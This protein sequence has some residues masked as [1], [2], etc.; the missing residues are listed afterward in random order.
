MRKRQ[1]GRGGLVVATLALVAWGPLALAADGRVPEREGAQPR[2]REAPPETGA[3]RRGMG[4]AG[5]GAAR[6]LAQ[7]VN[8]EVEEKANGVTILV[9]SQKPD[10]AQRIKQALPQ[11][12]NAMR[13][14]GMGMEQRPGPGMPEGRPA[15]KP[16]LARKDVDIHGEPLDDGVAISVTSDN[17]KVAEQIKRVMPQRAQMLRGLLQ[18]AQAGGGDPLVR[19]AMS[20]K[21]NTEV[22]PRPGGAA[23]VMTSDE[24]RLAQAIERALRQRVQ[25]MK[26]L[27]APRRQREEGAGA[28]PP[29][30]PQRGR[31]GRGGA[32]GPPAIGPG[33]PR[34]QGVQPPVRPEWPL[35]GRPGP[36]RPFAP[37]REGLGRPPMEPLVP[38]ERMPMRRPGL[39]QPVPPDWELERER[40]ELGRQ[41][42]A[43]ERER[44][45]L[46]REREDI[47]RIIREEI[48]RYIEESRGERHEP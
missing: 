43:L 41:R 24:P 14:T 25:S 37:G 8:I 46:M 31:M 30:A 40:A 1:I 47:R 28:R 45:A 38:P 9:T 3:M 15:P 32:E 39:E 16:F 10:V 23:L 6:P 19:L 27:S 5:E 29:V 22:E 34:R 17:P 11:R 21:V 13:Q 20:G 33:Q 44:Q 2:A 26:R 4:R 36:E 18:M 48:R 7:D 35:M 42:E 12:I